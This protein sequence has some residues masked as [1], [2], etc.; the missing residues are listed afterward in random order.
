[1]TYFVRNRFHPLNQLRR[2]PATRAV[3]RAIDLPLWTRLPEIAWQV[4]VRLMQ[5]LSYILLSRGL[6]P[7]TLALF[8]AITREFSVRSFWDVGANM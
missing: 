5:H 3:L 1:M 7:E 6:E 2:Y 8:R 4:K